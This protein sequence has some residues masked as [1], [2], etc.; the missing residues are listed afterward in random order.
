MYQ[1]DYIL[2]MIEMLGDMIAAILGLIKKGEYRQASEE[3]AKIY[4]KMLKEDAAFFRNIPENEL[5]HK[6]LRQYNYTNGHLEI[7]AELFY[8]EAELEY[9]QGNSTNCIEYLKKALML[10]KFIDREYKTYSSAR[11]IKM[12]NITSRIKTLIIN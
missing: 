8:A 5:T 10:F 7:L 1:K 3:M 9:A 12:E 11:L 2:R 6:L 4:Y